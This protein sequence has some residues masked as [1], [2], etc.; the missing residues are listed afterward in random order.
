LLLLLLLLLMAAAAIVRRA[1]VVG[2]GD[3]VGVDGG[4]VEVGFGVGIWG[5]LMD[6]L[7]GCRC[8]VGL[9]EAWCCCC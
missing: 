2:M 4:G 5:E 1:A 8:G 7:A 3:G 6:R 9:E